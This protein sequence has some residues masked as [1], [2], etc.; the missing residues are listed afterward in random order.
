LSL[1]RLEQISVDEFGQTPYL[2]VLTYPRPNL[3]IVK[4]RITQLKALGVDSVIFEGRTRVGRLGLL[5][6]GT[7]GLVV[8]V[9][10][11]GVVCALKIRRT[12]ANRESM[13]LEH[14]LTRMANKVGVGPKVVGATRD[15]LLMEWVQ[16]EQVDDWLT[17]IRGAG[18]RARLRNLIHSILNQCRKMDIL[19]LD[20]GQLSNLR[21]HVLIAEDRP[22][23]IDFESASLNRKSKNV[24]TAAQYLLVGGMV[25][26]RVRRMLGIKKV[27]PVLKTLTRYKREMSDESYASLLHT[28]GIPLPVS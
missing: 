25:S 22:T 2:N 7:V 17:K 16:G 24:T 14:R 18:S 9:E 15:F 20:H 28:F 26:K 8:K 10:T 6:I 11:R 13:D 21:K 5:G 27:E 4:G 1:T 19:N 3:R 23:I 12:D